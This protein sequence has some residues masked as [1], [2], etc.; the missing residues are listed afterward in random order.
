MREVSTTH[1][2]TEPWCLTRSGMSGHRRRCRKA[3]DDRQGIDGLKEPVLL[4]RAYSRGERENRSLV[5]V[6]GWLA[7]G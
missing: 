1:L 4:G 2:W 5:Q 3:W 6:D 7:A